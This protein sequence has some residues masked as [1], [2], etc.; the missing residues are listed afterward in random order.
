MI[1]TVMAVQLILNVPNSFLKETSTGIFLNT[2]FISLLAIVFVLMVTRLFKAFNSKDILDISEY[3]GGKP[4]KAIIGTAYITFFVIIFATLV[5]YMS[6]A[7]RLIYFPTTP[8]AF[9]LLFFLVPV[10]FINRLGLKSI[11]RINVLVLPSVLIGIFIIGASLFRSL[12]FYNLFP[13]LGYGANET[14]VVGLRNI[15]VFSTFGF[16]FLLPPF[17][18]EY[19]DFKKISLISTIVSAVYLI[20]TSTLL[21]VVFPYITHSNEMMSSYLLARLVQYGDFIQRIDALFIFV[22][23]F[24]TLTYLSITF[25]FILRIFK[26]VTAIK[27]EDE[28]APPI[29]MIILGISL[30]LQRS[31]NIEFI[32]QYVYKYFVF[33]LIFGISFLVLL[34]GYLKQKRQ[35]M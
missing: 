30:L 5:R 20:F 31:S 1:V 15:S 29:A 19:N 3:I 13:M 33:I 14:F 22:W 28:I 24:A 10:V 11:A 12:N 17:L 27:R 26:K 2:I 32:E 18:K 7:L 6:Q 4:L 16:L 35:D 21:L 8:I 23:I 25:F 9:I 34:L